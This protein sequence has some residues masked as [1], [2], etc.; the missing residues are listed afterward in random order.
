MLAVFDDASTLAAALAFEAALARAS[1]AE[2]LIS[3]RAAKAIEA[4]CASAS[5][6]A[7]ELA[8]EAAHAGT[9]A[10]PLVA[11]LRALTEPEAAAH[12]HAGATS[13]DL[14][15][16]VLMSQAKAGAALVITEAQGLA[17]ALARMAEEHAETPM[18]GRTL[19]QPAQPITFGLRVSNWL[20]GL[21]DGVRRFER[22]SALALS[23]QL[24]GAAG[25]LAGLGV[26]VAERMARDLGLGLAPIPW[27]ARRDGVVGLAT[28][29]A[30]LTGA[31]AKIARDIAL[32][33]QAEVGEAFEPRVAGRGGSSAMA[34]KRNPTGCQVAL[35]AALRAPGLAATVLAGLPQ[36]QERGL[37]G[38]QAEAP[39]LAELFGLAHAALCALRP[40]A[41]GLEIDAVAMRRRLQAATVDDDVG[42]AADL[43]RRALEHYRRDR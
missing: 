3:A 19:I 35:S 39:V 40:V 21:D 27:H 33:A 9:L 5:F 30:I 13:Q 34:H 37:G 25:A 38:W 11:R 42:H 2:G 31:V 26:A 4:A 24:G 41:E 43:V 15:D 14:A 28:S 6:D 32:M 22:E 10:I 12:V 36:E 23:V 7:A 29:L 8:E 16:T 17:D 1:A 20:L 18:L